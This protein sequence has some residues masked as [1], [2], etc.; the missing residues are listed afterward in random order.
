VLAVRSG[1][2]SPEQYRSYLAASG[3]ELDHRPGRTWRNLQDTAT[4]AQILYSASAQWDNWRRSVDYYP[5]G[6]LIW[7]DVDTT[8]RKLS[9]GKKSLND[10]CARFLGAGGNTPPKVVPYVFEDVVNG[11]NVIQS[12]D[13]AHFLNERLSSKAPHAPLAGVT[14]GGYRIEYTDQTNEFVRAA[15]SKARGV[16]AWY[17]LGMIVGAESTIADILMGSPAYNA[18]LGPGMKLVAINGRRASDDLLRQAIRESKGSTKGI[19][20]IID[21]DGFFKTL[22]VDYHGGERYPHLTRVPGAPAFLDE[23]LKPMIAHP[24][25][26]SSL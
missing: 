7:L 11:L 14:N 15:E 26:A 20:L 2:W 9:G 22:N 16:N 25:P 21:H 1:I 18:G 3:A 8:M 13:W 5:E 6:E 12:Y 10:F 17:S 4:A 23:I 24:Q 19:E